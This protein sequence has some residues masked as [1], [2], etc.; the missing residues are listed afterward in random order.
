MNI[1]PFHSFQPDWILGVLL[2]CFALLAW[3][4]Y[5]NR[6]RLRQILTAPF[7]KRY[8]SQLV[9]EGDLFSE[10]ISV[11]LALLYLL[12]IPL[13]AYE[14]NL[15]FDFIRIRLGSFLVYLIFSAAL[16][17]Y[18]LAKYILIRLL[19][20]IFKTYQTTREYLLNILVINFITGIVLLPF[21]TLMVYLKSPVLL[22]ISLCLFGISFVFRFGRGFLI[23]FSLKKFSYLYLFVYLCTLEILP[24]ILVA[25][26]LLTYHLK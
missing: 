23:G 26:I 11:P 25:K 16:D 18:W 19:G 10:R 21:L 12:V 13:L 3:A 15:H 6:T 5:F 1:A 17:L 24:L 2:L 4:Q 9:R 22:Y 8:M 14:T 20:S 7:L